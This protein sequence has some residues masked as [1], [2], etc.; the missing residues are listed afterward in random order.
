[1][2]NIKL[3]ISI[4]EKIKYNIRIKLYITLLFKSNP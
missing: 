3:F 2:N 1:M 4:N